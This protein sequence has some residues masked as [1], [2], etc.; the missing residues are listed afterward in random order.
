LAGIEQS[1]RLEAIVKIFTA[2]CLASAAIV[3]SSC[4]GGSSGTPGTGNA[5]VS[6]FLTDGPF[7]TSSGTVTAVNVSIA[8]VELVGTGGIQTLTTYS[9][10]Q[11]VNLLNYV[12]T[13]FS[14]GS[15]AVPAGHYQQVRLVLDTSQ[16][17]NTSVVVNG[18]TYPLTIPSA[19]G[20]YGFGNNSAIDNGDG[21]GTSGIK[22]NIGLNAQGGYTYAFTI[23]FNA[24]ESIVEANGKWILKPVLVATAQA[25]SGAISGTVKNNA[26]GAVSGAEVVAEQNG[27]IVNSGVTDTN[28]NFQ[29]NALP[30]GTYTLVVNNVWT[31][32]AGASETASGAD[33]TASVTDPNPVTVTNGQTTTVTLTD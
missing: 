30:A 17:A 11:T 28:G 9:P 26:G 6:A 20:P 22:V 2:I 25:T 23:D 1:I 21:I 31:N 3:L 13:P 27:S 33:G 10:A 15:A 18:T 14:L 16:S 19:T 4:G 7:R 12:T 5:T 8:K 32:Q 24:A 29:I